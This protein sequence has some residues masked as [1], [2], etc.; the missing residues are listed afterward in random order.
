MFVSSMEDAFTAI[1]SNTTV[2]RVPSP[3]GAV[4]PTPS[5]AI[6]TLLLAV[7]GGTANAP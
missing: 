4:V 1:T 5:A 3:S 2:A 7:I 6:V